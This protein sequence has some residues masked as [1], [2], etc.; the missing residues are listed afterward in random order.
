MDR[1]RA[2]SSGP[3]A[4]W[5]TASTELKAYAPRDVR[6]VE[7][8]VVIA[9]IGILVALLL[10]A[11]Q[12]AREAARRM[13]CG[14]NM[15]QMGIAMH[16][17][18]DTYKTLPSSDING[19]SRYSG[20]YVP[21]GQIRNFTGYL[22]MLPFYEQGPLHDQIDFRRATGRADWVNRGGGGTQPVFD[23]TYVKIPTLICPSDVPYDD[24]HTYTTC[25][26]SETRCASATDSRWIG[27]SITIL[28]PTPGITGPRNPPSDITVVRC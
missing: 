27:T 22:L 11:V 5:A 15:K 7:L 25:T 19:G 6:L 10:P 13:S 16:N 1:K 4:A 8:L 3:I 20:N 21:R 26:R 24:P 2:T 12:A 28:T 9:I 14:N 23:N 17:Y 18:H